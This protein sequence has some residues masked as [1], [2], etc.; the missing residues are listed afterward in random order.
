MKR[1]RARSWWVGS[2]IIVT[3]ACTRPPSEP[4]VPSPSTPVDKPPLPDELSVRPGINAPYF[5]PDSIDTY[6]GV[7]EAESREVVQHRD[8]IADA[9][10]LREGMVVADIGAGTGLFMTAIAGRVGDA[11]KLYAVDIV[12]AFLDR[13]RARVAADQLS[14]VTVVQGEERATGLEQASIDLAFMCDTYHHIEYPVTYLASLFATLRPSATL[15]LI[16]FERIEG[17]TRPSILSHVRANKKTVIEE[18]SEAG[19]VLESEVDLLEENY[20][21]R[22]IRPDDPTR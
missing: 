17:V 4:T 7:L 8:Q 12:P 20:Y 2:A 21:L 19:F 5:Q 15:V 6:S 18:V 9:I 14:N 3:L 10:G 16:D 11:G 1:P 22:F 13:L